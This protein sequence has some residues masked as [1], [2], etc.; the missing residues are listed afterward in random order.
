[1]REVDVEAPPLVADG[2]ISSPACMYT[3]HPA[4]S[5]RCNVH[6]VLPHLSALTDLRAKCMPKPGGVLRL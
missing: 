4:G 3:L 1:M 5:C 6:T 2:G